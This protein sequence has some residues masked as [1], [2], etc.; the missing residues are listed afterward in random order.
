MANGP[1]FQ[2]IN[3]MGAFQQGYGIAQVFQQNQAIKDQQEA[4]ARLQMQQQDAYN[5]FMDNP[6]F[7]SGAG[8]LNLLTPEQ[9]AEAQG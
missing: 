3:P 8:W 5:A 6:T 7:A 1:T 4:A 2:P 9:Q